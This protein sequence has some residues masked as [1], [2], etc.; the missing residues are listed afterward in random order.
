MQV[1]YDLG[2]IVRREECARPLASEMIHVRAP[3]AMEMD[4]SAK[5]L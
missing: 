5:R 1:E 4:G 2:V 3:N